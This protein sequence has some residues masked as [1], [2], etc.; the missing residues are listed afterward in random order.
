MCVR[1]YIINYILY[2]YTCIMCVYIGTQ[3]TRI[4][5]ICIVYYMMYRR[6]AICIHTIVIACT[7]I[8]H[9]LC[10]Y[11]LITPNIYYFVYIKC[12]VRVCVYV[13]V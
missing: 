4:Y 11:V 10:M 12:I 9:V 2:G 6:C 3:I 1:V 13:C 8:L 7:C 5:I